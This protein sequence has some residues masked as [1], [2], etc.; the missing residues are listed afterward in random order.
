MLEDRNTL[1]NIVTSLPLLYSAMV[2][3]GVGKRGRQIFRTA[4]IEV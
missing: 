3:A 4:M 1:T 2:P